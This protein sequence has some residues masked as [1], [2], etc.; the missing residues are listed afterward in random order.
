MS[1]TLMK[2]GSQ[3]ILDKTVFAFGTVENPLF[4][5]AVVA[6][7]IDY[8][9]DGKGFFNIS[10][11]LE[12]VDEGEKMLIEAPIVDSVDCTQSKNVGN[13]RRKKWFLTEGGRIYI[14]DYNGNEVAVD[15]ATAPVFTEQEGLI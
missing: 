13:L 4:D 14:D 6:E 10:Q 12:S 11:M 9:K 7:A 5:P 8:N 1:N 2:L 3:D 15:M